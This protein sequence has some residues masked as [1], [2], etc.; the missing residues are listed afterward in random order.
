M[1]QADW[2]NAIHMLDVLYCLGVFLYAAKTD[3]GM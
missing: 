3:Y 2:R 1:K